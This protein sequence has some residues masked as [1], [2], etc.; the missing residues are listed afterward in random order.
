MISQDIYIDREKWK[1]KVGREKYYG[2]VQREDV[3]FWMPVCYFTL[4]YIILQVRRIFSNNNDSKRN[5]EKIFLLCLQSICLI[6]YSFEKYKSQFSNQLF[7]LPI[8]ANGTL[9]LVCN[10]NNFTYAL[11]SEMLL[12]DL[13]RT[14]EYVVV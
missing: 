10:Y 2:T 13:L 4:Q 8:F 6:H 11:S 3:F 9:Y 1:T 7:C 14:L 5:G 12:N